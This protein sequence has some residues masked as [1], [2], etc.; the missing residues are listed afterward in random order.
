M[1]HKAIPVVPDLLLER[2]LAAEHRVVRVA[3][4]DEAGRGALAG[5]VFAAAVVLPLDDMSLK[6]LTGV[7]D[8][9]LLTPAARERLFPLICERA[10]CFGVGYATAESIDRLGILPATRQA[11]A[12]AIAGLSPMA[13][14]LLIDGPIRLDA[15]ALPQ[16]P[17]IRGDQR[18]LCIAAA[19]V[20]AKV[21]R[22]RYMVA[23]GER[24]PDY[25]FVRHKGYGTAEHRRALER[26]GPCAEHRRTFSPVM[27]L[28][29][30]DSDETA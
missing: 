10:L 17:I 15:I 26:L 28:T 6:P 4:I 29:R 21:S 23:L 16:R 27:N 19:S 1:P 12:D 13:E 20:L 24:F 11:M 25:G 7:R 5:P 18:S 8:S 22:D 3:G 2:G 30:I 14:A 9:K